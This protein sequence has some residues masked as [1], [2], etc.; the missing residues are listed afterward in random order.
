MTDPQL[1]ATLDTL[2]ASFAE[3]IGAR[4]RNF[5]QA[6]RRAGR[7]LPRKHRAAAA[8]LVDAE[9]MAA[10][11]RLARLIDAGQIERAVQDLETW[12]ATQDPRERRK[13]AII[14]WAALIGFYVLATA[15]LVIAFLVWRGYV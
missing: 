2:R 11:P 13:T 3:R 4:G 8:T 1:Q 7:R 9:R 14:N 5:A 15:G 12:L 6:V 10:N